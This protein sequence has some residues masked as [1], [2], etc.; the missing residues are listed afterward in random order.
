VILV[1]VFDVVAATVKKR[2][3][4]VD[5]EQDVT[6]TLKTALYKN[7]LQVDSFN[8]PILALKNFQ[9]GSYDLL[10]IDID[11]PQ[12]SGFDLYEK[13]REIDN[14]VKIRF[15]TTESQIKFGDAFPL[16]DVNCFIKK[17]TEDKEMVIKQVNKII[18]QT[19]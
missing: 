6:S 4:V 3:L 1:I 12:M 10:I 15:L 9:A 11:M 7:G 17:P 19:E 13:I 8:N 16:L 5:D 18:G 2:I 14:K